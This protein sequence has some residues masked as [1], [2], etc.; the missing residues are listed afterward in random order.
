MQG[1][2]ERLS[3]AVGKGLVY[4]QAPQICEIT[5]QYKHRRDNLARGRVEVE[6]DTGR[7]MGVGESRSDSN[8]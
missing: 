3:S 6:R 5:Q 2:Q 7:K 4:F 1:V 8:T